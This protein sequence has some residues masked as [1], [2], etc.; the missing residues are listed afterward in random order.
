MTTDMS[1]RDI[2]STRKY[3]Q[4]EHRL[5]EVLYERVVRL[6]IT[7]ASTRSTA[8]KGEGGKPAM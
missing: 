3:E 4:A 6:K 2:S 1:K 5:Y 7:V 8:R